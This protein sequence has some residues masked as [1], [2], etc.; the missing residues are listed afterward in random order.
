MLDVFCKFL[1]VVLELAHASTDLLRHCQPARNLTH[2]LAYGLTGGHL[3]HLVGSS[4][5]RVLLGRLRWLRLARLGL[6]LQLRV[7]LILIDLGRASM[8][9]GLNLGYLDP[10]QIF[11]VLER[12]KW[13]LLQTGRALRLLIPHLVVYLIIEVSHPGPFLGT[14]VVYC[15]DTVHLATVLLHLVVLGHLTRDSHL[16]LGRR[17]LSRGLP[18]PDLVTAWQHAIRGHLLQGPRVHAN[19]RR[20]R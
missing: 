2:V 6:R 17:V 11:T 8:L 14:I 9:F 5:L 10:P 1:G 12:A 19:L 20:L 3:L 4:L 13:H 18:R 16:P 15:V 7:L